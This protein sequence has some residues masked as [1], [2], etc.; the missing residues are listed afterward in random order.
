MVGRTLIYTKI[1]LSMLPMIIRFAKDNLTS[2]ICWSHGL[3]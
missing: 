3:K 1:G 2:V